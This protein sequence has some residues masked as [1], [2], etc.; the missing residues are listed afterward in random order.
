MKSHTQRKMT[1]SYSSF[2][3]SSGVSS[4]SAACSMDAVQEMFTDISEGLRCTICFDLYTRY[5]VKANLHIFQFFCQFLF[6]IPKY[7]VAVCVVY[8]W[9][10]GSTVLALNRGQRQIIK[11]GKEQAITHDIYI[12]IHV[13]TTHSC[14]GVHHV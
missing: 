6:L 4:L 7:S 1:A 2:P 8:I 13:L 10:T 9:L 12:Q 14:R 5:V 3:P 11:G